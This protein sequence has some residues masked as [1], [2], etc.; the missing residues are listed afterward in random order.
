[1]IEVYK[2]KYETC[3][4]MLE[5]LRRERV[6]LCDE[7]LSYAGILDPMAEGIVPVLVGKDEN[8]RR[9]AY[10][11]TKKVY[12]V[13]V[14]VG[15]RTD[16]GD[17]L[18][19][20]T[21][22]NSAARALSENDPDQI[23]SCFLNHTRSFTQTVPMHSNRKVAGKPLW[24]WMLNGVQIPEDKRPQNHVTIFDLTFLGKDTIDLEKLTRE[25][26]MMKERFGE[27]FRMPLVYSSWE[28]FFLDNTA[29]EFI[30]L[31]FELYVSSGFYVRTFVEGVS[32]AVGVPLV[33]YS[34][35]RSRVITE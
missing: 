24:L 10:H 7:V 35:V 22:E 23:I 13:R 15:V 20:V 14:L 8:I 11:G 29:R 12:T 25:V 2:N 1:M 26:A 6:E 30:V 16:S 31:D 27:R 34:L 18:G 3:L 33:V 28:R 9:G 21:R 17:L 4:E 32:L 5:R 19:V